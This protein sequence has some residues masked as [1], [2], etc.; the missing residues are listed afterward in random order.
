MSDEL[1]P[2]PSR[3]R[4]TRLLT[5]KKLSVPSLSMPDDPV[6][7][8]SAHPMADHG[9]TAHLQRMQ[10][11]I[12]ANADVRTREFYLRDTDIRAALV[13]LDGLTDLDFLNENVMKPLML[14]FSPAVHALETENRP[15]VMDLVKDRYL[16]VNGVKR[17]ATSTEVVT[18]VFRGNTALFIDGVAEALVIE[19]KQKKARN[20]EEPLTEALV[21]GP[22]LGFN[23][24]LQ[25]NLAILRQLVGNPDLK[26]LPYQVGR[27][28]KKEL[29]IVYFEGIAND[30]LV[31]EVQ[32]RIARIDI[33]DVPETGYIELLIQDNYLT[34][35]PQLQNTERPDRLIAA[36]M[37]GRVGILLDG[38]PFTLIAPVTFAMF[39]QS[40]EDYY[41]R[42][43]PGSLIRLLRYFSA[44]VSLYLPSIYISFVSFHQG[45]IPTTLAISIAATREGVPF[46]SIIES[47]IMEIAIEILRE[48]G[49]RLPRPVGQT[50]GLVGGLVIGEAAVQAGIVS[51]IMV[52]VVSLTAISSFAIPE[53]AG[54]ISLRLLRFGA[55]VCAAVLGLF[56]VIFFFLIILIHLV[57]LKSF[58]VPYIA[59]AAPIRWSDW[60]D[61]LI[62]LPQGISDKRPQMLFPKDQVRMRQTSPTKRK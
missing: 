59:P 9:I 60:K 25:D 40:P 6:D 44:F 7:D 36:L 23:E 34:P 1:K 61:F 3:K 43:I 57:K 46:P 58:G 26:I 38:T 11:Q 19:A 29:A 5:P 51:P 17:V 42:W 27:R 52:M 56:G 4:K 28:T 16:T 12:G 20:I 50:V 18:H 13:Y 55:M 54:G 41:Q 39:L 33:D 2:R 45:L 8:S 21:R 32:N 31:Q 22:R 30:E 53:Y 14:N 24:N 10:E 35:F 47:L 62:R 48:A 37:E 49:L 15:D